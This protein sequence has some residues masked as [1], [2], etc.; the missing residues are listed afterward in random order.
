MKGVNLI[1]LRMRNARCQATQESPKRSIKHKHQKKALQNQTQNQIKESPQRR[2]GRR[3]GMIL[4][5][6]HQRRASIE[7]ENPERKLKKRRTQNA[8]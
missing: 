1:G 7:T 5:R 3:D 4:R 2:K 8:E 6:F